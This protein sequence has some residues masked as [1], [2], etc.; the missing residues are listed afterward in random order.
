M[1]IKFKHV[2]GILV[3]GFLMISCVSDKDFKEKVKK[4]IEENPEMVMDAI[5]N[6]TSLSQRWYKGGS[7]LILKSLIA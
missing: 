3:V 6:S 2:F 1:T 5:N 7:A 4:T